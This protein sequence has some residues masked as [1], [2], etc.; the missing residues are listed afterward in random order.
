MTSGY[1]A[2]PIFQATPRQIDNLIHRIH[3]GSLTIPDFQRDFTW[4]PKRTQELLRSVMSRYPAG[5]LLFWAMGS[6]SSSFGWRPVAGAPG[7]ASAPQELI[8]DGQQRL[9]CLYRALNDRG[10][11]RFYLRLSVLVDRTAGRVLTPTEIDFDKAIFWR[12]KGPKDDGF[13]EK[14]EAQY[15]NEVF[16][17]H[18]HREFDE[19]LDNYISNKHGKIDVD[20]TKRLYRQVRDQFLTPLKSYGFPVVTLP[21]S[22]SV[23]AVCNVFETLNKTGKPLGAFELLTAKLYPKN[24]KLRDLW[25]DALATHETLNDF[26][27]EPYSVMQAVALRSHRSAQRSTVLTQVTAADVKDHWDSCVRGYARVLDLLASDCGVISS[28]WLPYSMLLVPMA[29][30]WE[31]VMQL[32]GPVRQTAIDRL[33]QYFWCTVFTSNF[34]QGANSQAGADYIKLAEWVKDPIA[35]APEAI[36][37]LHI[38]ASVLAT[39]T[40]RRKAIYAGLIALSVQSGARDF[41]TGEKLTPERL[42]QHRI[43]SHHVFPKAYLGNAP[44]KTVKQLSPELALNRVLLDPTTNKTIAKNA[45]SAYLATLEGT[46][47]SDSISEIFDSHLVSDDAVDALRKDDYAGFVRSRLEDVIQQI[48]HVTQRPVTRDDDGLLNEKDD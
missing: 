40:T 12:D 21:A 6:D 29:A 22:T 39:A 32:K 31:D 8:L 42:R 34:D 38:S 24:V 20:A 48:E 1:D 37:T 14:P 26:G 44:K 4:E 16:P 5:T 3:D 47:A 33:K 27:I 30:V 43:D 9:T 46:I 35:S 10:D 23:D 19:W 15:E 25:A 36:E 28:K 7:K 41:H 11:E 2:D 18:K 45:P 17:L 13:L